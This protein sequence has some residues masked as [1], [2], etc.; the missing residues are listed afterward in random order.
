M[1][2]ITVNAENVQTIV[3]D[4]LSAERKVTRNYDALVV[5]AGLDHTSE[6]KTITES[7]HAL[8]LLAYPGTDPSRLTGK[9]KNHDQ[10]WKDARA[11][12]AGLVAAIKRAAPESEDNEPKP[13]VLRA[14]LSG[15]G[16]GTVTID[17]S[18][19]LYV[20]LVNK[21]RGEQAAAA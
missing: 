16:G 14:S 5:F 21:I 15:E 8:I 13:V 18:D 1:K 20:A 10:R 3:R 2:T 6:S 4:T 12:R 11:I 7:A 17:P 9:N 19:P